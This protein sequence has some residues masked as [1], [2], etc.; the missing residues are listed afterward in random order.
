MS[1]GNGGPR[2]VTPA[3]SGD[4]AIKDVGKRTSRMTQ[5][6]AARVPASAETIAGITSGRSFRRTSTDV[7]GRSDATASK[8][9]IGPIRAPTGSNANDR[10]SAEGRTSVATAQTSRTPIITLTVPRDRTSSVSTE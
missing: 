5:S 2:W 10:R 6:N 8:E 1:E 9:A 4:V 7:V 3:A